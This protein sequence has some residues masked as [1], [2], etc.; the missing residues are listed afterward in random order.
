V[1]GKFNGQHAD[2]VVWHDFDEEPLYT[3]NGCNRIE[4][5]KWVDIS[6]GKQT[7]LQSY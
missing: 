2:S 7:S 6:K 5:R 4:E 1:R 3:K